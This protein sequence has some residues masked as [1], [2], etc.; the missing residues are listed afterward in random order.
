M[1]RTPNSIDTL[2]PNNRFVKILNTL[3]IA[4]N[5]PYHSVIGDRGRG[6]T[7]NS[8]D[9]VVAY[10]SS[11]LEGAKSEEI[12]PSVHGSNASPEGIA[13]VERILKEN[14]GVQESPSVQKKDDNFGPLIRN[15]DVPEVSP[16]SCAHADTHSAPRAA[17]SSILTSGR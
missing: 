8:S 4:K 7:P 15:E 2:S 11:H 16:A 6:D 9:G 3:P 10:W 1:N 12:V 5:V 13:E 17:R 14:L